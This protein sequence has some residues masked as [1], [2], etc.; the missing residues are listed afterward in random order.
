MGTY[1]GVTCVES[2]GTLIIGT[3]RQPFILAG[4][5]LIAILDNGL[6]RI[7]PDVTEK[8]EYDEFYHDYGTGNWLSMKLYLIPEGILKS[9]P[10]EGRVES[11][12][13]KERNKMQI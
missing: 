11:V 9:C 13:F 2:K 6:W 5:R 7:A 8:R 4:H 12:Y 3:E 10:D 1:F